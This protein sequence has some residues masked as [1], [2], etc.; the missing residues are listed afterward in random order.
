MDDVSRSIQS[1]LRQLPAL[2][3]LLER[4][5]TAAL[6]VRH[7]R[8]ALVSALRV[9]TAAAR[10][11]ILTGRGTAQDGDGQDGDGQDG[12]GQ[13]SDGRGG[14][15]GGGHGQT[16]EQLIAQAAADLARRAAPRLVRVLNATGIIVH[17]NLGRAPLAAAAVAAVSAVAAGYCNLEYDLDAGVRG[18]R[19]S[20]VAD[21][22]AELTGAEAALVVNNNAAAVML[23]LGA[24]A[25]GGEVI[26]SRGELVEIGGS[27]R[28]PDIIRQSGAR[29]VEV[30][31]TNK[32]R[33]A[34]YAA[35]IGPETRALLKVHQSNFRIGGFTAS[36]AL[37]ELAP[38]AAARGVML[39]EDLGSG[40]LLDLAACGG[41]LEPTVR[42]AVAAGP[43]LIT[44]S[45]DKLLGGPQAGLVLGRRE[46][47]G[48]LRQHPLLRAVRI[49]KLGLAALEATLRLYHDEDRAR[50]EV[51]VLRM[52]TEPIETV[53]ARANKLAARIL[54]ATDG[55]GS[56][57][58]S[59]LDIAITAEPAYAGGGALPETAVPSRQV[60]LA[61]EAPSAGTL[62]ARLRLGHPAVI[63]RLSQ[64]RL[65]L[66]VRTLADGEL[67]EVA[68][69]IATALASHA[70]KTARQGASG[71]AEERF[72]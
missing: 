60:T 14:Y 25:A 11:H 65:L 10:Q 51:P 68:A 37:E 69:A 56:G 46:A 3:Q 30:G 5:D 42:S 32:T 53:A 54:A 4:P 17:T 21:L 12:H 1:Q 70:S 45:G 50:R 48:R 72:P 38:L 63:G 18:S 55:H 29:L 35:A 36:V 39:V 28:I 58:S 34:D 22:L 26:V 52:V 24:L 27:F 41:G 59:R 2:Q 67:E 23:A 7:G 19:H 15:G 20:I 33:L 49:D 44:M 43:D 57:V 62:A 13:D 16:A 66:D 31:T 47:I 71:G 6:A 9:A 64:G 8:A 40:S 61:T